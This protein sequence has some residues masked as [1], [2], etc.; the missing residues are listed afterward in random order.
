MKNMGRA[1]HFRLSVVGFLV[2][3]V[4]SS[5]EIENRKASTEPLTDVQ[6]AD[7]K[8]RFAQ[9]NLVGQPVVY[10]PQ[11]FFMFAGSPAREII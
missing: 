9:R 7:K 1:S 8:K 11:A 2:Y 10:Q 5:T 3:I 4:S 6:Q